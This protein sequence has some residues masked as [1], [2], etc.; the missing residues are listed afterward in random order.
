[1]AKPATGD[2][3]AMDYIPEAT[4]GLSPAT[5]TLEDCRHVSTSLGL[6][7]TTFEST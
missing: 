5:Q 6:S 3:N 1:M 7:K 4:Y 2:R